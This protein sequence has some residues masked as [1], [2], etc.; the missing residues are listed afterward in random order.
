[1]KLKVGRKDMSSTHWSR[2]D[3]KRKDDLERKKKNIKRRRSSRVLPALLEW[4]EIGEASSYLG[5]FPVPTLID[6]SNRVAL[7]H[8][9]RILDRPSCPFIAYPTQFTITA[10]QTGN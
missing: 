10:L 7:D 9:E 5:Q 2:R 4:K 1:M 3:E 8:L 6:R